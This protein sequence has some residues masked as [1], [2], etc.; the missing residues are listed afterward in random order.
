MTMITNDDL[1]DNVLVLIR[2]VVEPYMTDSCIVNTSFKELLGSG[3]GNKIPIIIGR[4]SFEGLYYCIVEKYPFLIDG[5]TDF[6]NLL[7]GDVKRSHN[8]SELRQMALRLKGVYF[9][10]R[11]PNSTD[12]FLQ[13][14]NL[15]SYRT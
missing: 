8:E 4:N 6:V 1:M 15:L 5:I 14:L 7:P 10:F 3:W 13:F 2:P 11:H 9:D 12:S